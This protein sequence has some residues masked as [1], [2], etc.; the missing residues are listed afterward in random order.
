MP[1]IDV[2]DE[3][4][5]YGTAN[6]RP[7]GGA[8]QGHHVPGLGAGVS[9]MRRG[10]KSTRSCRLSRIV[11]DVRGEKRPADAEG[12]AD[13]QLAKPAEKF[14]GRAAETAARG[15]AE[16]GDLLSSSARPRA[17]VAMA[18]GILRAG[19]G[20]ELRLLDEA[21]YRLPLGHRLPAAR[22]RPGASRYVAIHHPF[23]APVDEDL[24]L[25]ETDPAKVRAKAYD[26]VLN[27]DEIGGGSIRIHRRDVQA[28]VFQLLGISRRGGAG[29]FGFLLDALQYGAPPHGG[30]ALGLDRLVMLLS[31]SS[32][33]DVIA[34]PKTASNTDLHDGFALPGAGR[35]AAR[36]G[37]ILAVRMSRALC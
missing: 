27:G 21:A 19:D 7:R 14:L 13:D 2:S 18:M 16:A 31:A 36:A 23:T 29:Q 30:I 20:P 3:L 5:T 17:P 12:R 6:Y 1:I 34:F 9:G 26:I 24:A 37:G 32:I 28:K 8:G 15:G 11:P 35:A 33:R 4:R 10:R 25:L 22:V